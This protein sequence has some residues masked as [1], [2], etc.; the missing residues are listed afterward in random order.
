MEKLITLIFTGLRAVI[1]NYVTLYHL[2]DSTKVLSWRQRK[3]LLLVNMI[4]FGLLALLVGMAV[5]VVAMI[6]DLLFSCTD[7]LLL[8]F[9][10]RC[11]TFDFYF[12]IDTFIT[13]ISA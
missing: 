9:Q 6:S 4:R 12:S 5:T 13:S 11:F 1:E 8:L 10:H 2:D 7:L 3:I